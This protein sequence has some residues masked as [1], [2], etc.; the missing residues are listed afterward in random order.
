MEKIPQSEIRIPNLDLIIA[1]RN[2]G[3]VREIRRALKGLGIRVRP[4]SGFPEVPPVEEDGATFVENALKKARSYSKYFG[5]LTVADDSGLEVDALK[6]LPGV[7]SARYGG[8]RASDRDKNRKLLKEMNG[9]PP[10]KR[11]AKF[12]CVIAVV[13]PEGKEAVIE[14][15]C[16]GK[17]GLKEVGSKGF[18][19]DPLF[20]LPR[21][22]KTMAQLSVEEK[23]RISHRGKALRKLRKI[24]PVF[25]S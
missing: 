22:G 3:K 5:Q 17:V 10:S 12:K 21:S 20:V 19:Y 9:V 11:G 15:S 13:S 14:A 16:S 6:G 24:L 25:L 1:T 7:H 18:G 8:E 23:K 4:L 2:R